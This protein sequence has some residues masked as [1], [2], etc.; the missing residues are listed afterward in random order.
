MH[1]PGSIHVRSQKIGGRA[2]S[3][4]ILTGDPRS[5]L[6]MQAAHAPPKRPT[7]SSKISTA[8]FPGL[9]SPSLLSNSRPR[10]PIVGSNWPFSRFA[11]PQPCPERGSA[12][13]SDATEITTPMSEPM[14]DP[15]SFDMG[16]SDINWDE[17]FD[18]DSFLNFSGQAYA[19]E[20]LEG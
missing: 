5:S 1:P 2:P 12:N 10:P 14:S 4:A 15:Y 19:D 16:S 8:L 11:N 9:I 20:G 18:Y 7:S 13:A 3:V 17:P 6:G